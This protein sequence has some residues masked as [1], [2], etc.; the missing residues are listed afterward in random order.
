MKKITQLILNIQKC[1]LSQKD[2]DTLISFLK[3]EKPDLNKFLS[4]LFNICKVGNECLKL[5]DIDIGE[6][7]Q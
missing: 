5:L 7:I 1:N 2:K 4:T 6:I 3:T